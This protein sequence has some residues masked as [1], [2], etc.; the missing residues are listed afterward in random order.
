MRRGYLGEPGERL[1]AEVTLSAKLAEDSGGSQ[2]Y[3]MDKDIFGG[4]I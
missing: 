4:K 2:S 3:A 1:I